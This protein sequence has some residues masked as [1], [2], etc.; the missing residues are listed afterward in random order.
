MEIIKRYRVVIAIV[1][2]ILILV[3][4]RSFATNHFQSDAEKW[5]EPSVAGSN[6]I[7]TEQL[8]SLKGEILLINFGKERI[9][10]LNIKVTTLNIL[11]D[12]L[13]IKNNINTIQKHNGP[14]LLYTADMSLS[15]RIWML[16]SQMGVK[17]IYLLAKDNDNEVFKNKFRPDTL[18]RPEL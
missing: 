11:P 2:P 12:S 17:N 1:L 10:S 9:T 8:P 7:S 15:A 18:I 16:L 6:I 3:I 5:A 13:L 4:I 14:V